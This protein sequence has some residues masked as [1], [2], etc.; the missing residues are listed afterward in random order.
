MTRR[1]ISLPDDLDA[2]ISAAAER[3]DDGNVSAWLA[4]VAE[5]ALF[6][7]SLRSLRYE[8]L[9]AAHEAHL[10]TMLNW[11]QAEAAAEGTSRKAA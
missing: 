3:T 6:A 11:Q 5:R 7:D 2:Q 9:D 4:R 10:R 8:Q 1:T